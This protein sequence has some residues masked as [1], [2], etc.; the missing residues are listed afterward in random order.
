MSQENVEQENVRVVL[1]GFARFNA[2]EEDLEW[3]LRTLPEVM[4]M[5]WQPDGEYHT[6]RKRTSTWSGVSTTLGIGR[7]RLGSSSRRTWST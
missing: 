4:A 3:R 7:S 6:D 2:V 5:Y 1:E